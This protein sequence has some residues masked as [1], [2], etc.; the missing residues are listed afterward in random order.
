MSGNV[1]IFFSLMCRCLGKDGVH[2]AVATVAFSILVS[3]CSG[4]LHSASER[5]DYQ[6]MLKLT[7]STSSCVSVTA[8]GCMG[9]RG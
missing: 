8:V 5:L 7:Y 3:M 6:G 9:C 4:T 1:F 2:S